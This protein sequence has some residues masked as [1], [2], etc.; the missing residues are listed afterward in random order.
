MVKQHGNVCVYV[1][2]KCRCFEPIPLSYARTAEYDFNFHRAHGALGARSLTADDDFMRQL[3]SE[4]CVRRTP[5][6]APHLLG[7]LSLVCDI[8]QE[9]RPLVLV[10]FN[11]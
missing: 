5:V 11:W 9:L 3:H 6:I 10:S 8:S 2:D 1:C 7:E 4:R